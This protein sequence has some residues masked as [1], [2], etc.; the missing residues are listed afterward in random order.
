M[1][2]YIDISGFNINYAN[3]GNS[4]LSYGAITFLRQKGLLVDGQ[5]LVK[6]IC[7]RNFLKI[8]NFFTRKEIV[9]VSGE[10]YVLNYVP[11]FSFERFLLLRWK[12]VLPFTPFGRHIRE[13]EY[14]AAD[15]G[16]DGFSDIY[17]D[18]LFIARLGQTV[19][20]KNAKVPLIMLPMTIGPFGKENNYRIAKEVLLYATKVYIR[21]CKFIENLNKLGIKY[22]Q[23]KDLSAYMLPERW[24]IEIKKPSIGINVSGL[25]YSNSFSNL[26]GQF[27]NYPDLV[28]EL[29]SHFREKGFYV[30]LIPHSYNYEAPEKNNDDM[31]ACRQA[32][33]KLNDKDNVI[34][35]DY[36][37]SSPKVK[38]VISQM[39]FFIGTRMHANFA[40]IYTGTPVFGLA[41]SY[42]FAGA[43][44]AN[45]LDPDKQTYMINNLQPNEIEKVINRIENF[46]EEVKTHPC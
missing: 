5:E 13:T 29:I 11:I 30:Y 17:G 22:E 19:L 23:E 2:K 3:R 27:D 38:F 35:L 28:N 42:K 1:K 10:N 8:S 43:F 16:G 39:D 26:E 25:A 34:L 33:E 31:V 45:G 6:Y 32:Y 20:L 14:E 44:M 12:F 21:D 46:I 18:D 9:C 36:N 40:A 4:A 41:Y 15:Y 24:N 37:L 7:Y